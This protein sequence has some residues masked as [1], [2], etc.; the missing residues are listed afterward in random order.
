LTIAEAAAQL[1]LSEGAIRNRLK[2]GTLTRVKLGSRVFVLVDGPAINP[3][4]QKINPG[5]QDPTHDL[6]K[7]VEAQREEI[8]RLV[9]QLEAATKANVELLEA[10][11][12]EQVLHQGSQR[13]QALP[14]PSWWSR[15]FR[16][17]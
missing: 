5:G 10:L 14:A 17:E 13:Q 15:M 8:G 6:Q 9:D 11:R 1:G 16:R 2:R 12:R 3:D 7:L 4:G